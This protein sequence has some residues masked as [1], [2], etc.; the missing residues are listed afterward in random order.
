MDGMRYDNLVRLKT[1]PDVLETVQDWP[2]KSQHQLKKLVHKYGMPHE[3]TERAVR[4]WYNGSWKHTTVYRQGTPHQFPSAHVD[5][6]KQTVD[7]IVPEH[8]SND[9]LEFNGSLLIDSTRGEL[10]A[11]CQ[12]E[13]M[14]IL[15]LNLAHD[16][17]TG[18]SSVEQAKQRL[19]RVSHMLRMRWPEPYTQ[20][21]RFQ[22]DVRQIETMRRGVGE[23]PAR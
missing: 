10:A 11:F 5:V 18:I 21:L 3:V 14:N 9:L 20:A 7:Y 4:W 15:L 8:K 13:E 1:V 22:I 12:S 17:A 16:I 19:G 23:S 2:E 6:V